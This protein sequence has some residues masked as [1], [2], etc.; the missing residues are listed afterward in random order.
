M[1]QNSILLRSVGLKSFDHEYPVQ[2]VF[3]AT[4]LC[5]MCGL[6]AGQKISVPNC[7][8][9]LENSI[10]DCI[11]Y[12]ANSITSTTALKVKRVSL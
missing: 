11:V 6:H 5:F 4:L 12:Y 9:R 3:W 7:F 10:W 1:R 8:A 2:T